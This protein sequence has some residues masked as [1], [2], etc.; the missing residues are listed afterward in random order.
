MTRD[1]SNRRSR[2]ALAATNVQ[3]KRSRRG[4]VLILVLVV[5]VALSFSAYTYT[6]LMQAEQEAAQMAGR[7][8][9]S[10]YLVDSGVDAIR[11]YLSLKDG[12]LEEAGGTYDNPAQFQGLPVYNDPVEGIGGYVTVVAPALD[13]AG[14]L[15]GFRFGL[16]DES[17][18]LNL[19]LLPAVDAQLPGGGRTLLM[20][21]PLM[22]EEIAD[23]I[24]DY[25]DEDDEPRDYGSERDYYAGLEPGYLP[26][27]GPLETIEELLLVRG[28]LPE[29]LFGA[30][31]NHNGILDDEEQAGASDLGI[32]P[33]MALGWANYLTLWSK[34]RNYTREGL[35][36]IDLN[37]E[38]LETLYDQLTTVFNSE[39]ANFIVAMRQSG[40]YT[41]EDEPAGPR[42]PG[43]LDL[44]QPATY[45]FSQILDLVDARVEVQFVGEDEPTILESPLKSSGG[46]GLQLPLLLENA[47]TVASDNIPG[48]INIAQCT[49]AVLLGVPGM[50][51]EVADEII[52]RRDIV[53]DDNDANRDYETWLLVEGIVDLAMMKQMLPFICVGGDVHKAELVGYFDDGMGSSRAEVVI[54]RTGAFPRIVFW[55]DKSHLPLGY[56]LDT[57][58]IGLQQTR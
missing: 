22:T 8:I 35:P 4:I 50:T 21:L 26:R 54:D 36:R 9:Q 52:R 39:W 28:V 49:R 47:T 42:L 1:S 44:T 51:E 15:A 40:P 29:L 56:Q 5:V 31:D 10:R 48:R 34:E 41:G 43:A 46:L 14:A 13:D 16:V 7:R 17:T 32:P 57:L 3:G 33:D 24:M 23:A 12:D 25:I 11:L 58:G 27:N 38:D 6:A 18:K 30:D 37:Q 2:V 20:S 19:N 45:S 55:R 53:R